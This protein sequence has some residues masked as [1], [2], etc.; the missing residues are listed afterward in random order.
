[1]GGTATSAPSTIASQALQYSLIRPS[2][3]QVRL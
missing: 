2:V 1:M 3:L